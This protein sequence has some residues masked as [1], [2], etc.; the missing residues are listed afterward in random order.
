MQ[1][2]YST[3]Q[4]TEIFSVD[5]STV[6]RWAKEESWGKIK[7]KGKGG[8]EEFFPT[9]MPK[10]RQRR[11]ST[12]LACQHAA[13]TVS[14]QL[15][16]T[17]NTSRNQHSSLTGLPEFAQSRAAARA[18]IVAAV[19]QLIAETGEN[20]SDVLF[21][22]ASLYKHKKAPVPDWVYESCRTASRSA[23][24]DWMLKIEREGV[25]RLAKT[26]EKRRPRNIIANNPKLQDFVLGMLYEFP[27][28]SAAEIERGLIARFGPE[29]T[30][31]DL[32]IKLPCL[33]RIQVW[34]KSWKQ[35]NA[36]L[37]LAHT[38]P[39]AFKSKHKAAFGDAAAHITYLNQEWQSD[40]T[41]ADLILNDGRRHTLNLTIDVFSRRLIFHVSR[42][43][44]SAAVASGFRKCLHSWGS[45][46]TWKT[47]N[48]SDY[49]NAHMDRIC[50]SLDILHE[51]C[52]P[53]SP[54]QKPFVERAFKTFLHSHVEV[55]AGYIGHSVADR[56]AI[57][58]QK[59][60]AARL[61]KKLM[62]PGE[63]VEMNLSP[64]ELQRICDQWAE[65]VYGNEPHAGLDGMSPNAKAAAYEGTIQRI[66]DERA[67]DILLLPCPG[68]NGL[69]TVTKKGIRI[70]SKQHGLT[71]KGHYIGPD[72]GI[73]IGRRVLVRL[74]DTDLGR[75]YLSDPES[76]EYLGKATHPSW[77][78]WSPEKI[79]DTAYAAAR[80]QKADTSE[81]KKGWK[82]AAK[83]ADVKDIGNEILETAARKASKAAP[84]SAHETIAH[85]TPHL[86]QAARVHTGDLVPPTPE[87]YAAEMAKYEPI[88]DQGFVPPV[89]EHECA[90]LWQDNHRSMQKGQRF[91][92]D[93]IDWMER[94]ARSNSVLRMLLF[95]KDIDPD[96]KLERM[97]KTPALPEA[98]VP[99]HL[100]QN[101]KNGAF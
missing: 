91:P 27:H 23:I 8:G 41:K 34:L 67:L 32:S 101:Q 45:P 100:A 78:G 82:A 24:R 68:G 81:Q 29:G 89:E 54:E 55:L 40:G 74:D 11:I 49:K 31:E 48:G 10:V 52:D 73:L 71:I 66:E 58:S 79:R 43:S 38:N 62:T 42:T 5:K 4:L 85:T 36:R 84:T 30:A 22:F 21:E 44:S 16:R 57:E 77:A 18:A 6:L 59:S 37:L 7:R 3:R 17:V 98:G 76:G 56:K 13:K 25:R 35:T 90:E 1:N 46:G 93:E 65:H 19:K 15:N 88:Q 50:V 75:V 61:F 60:F 92:D 70:T 80:G 39:D 94:Y 51:L 87:E 83:R 99:A 53:F 96:A 14:E 63:V 97:K 28:A 72:L 26:H 69:R 95:G 9:T 2:S 12:Y 33:R 20:M 86:E 64:E 47:D